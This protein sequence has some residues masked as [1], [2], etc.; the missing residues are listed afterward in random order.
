[1]PPATLL[2]LTDLTVSYRARPVLRQL[3]LRLEGDQ[4]W[5]VLGPNGAGKTTLARVLAGELRHFT[6]A[7]Q[8]SS[9]LA[10]RGVAYVCFERARALL[11]RDRKLDVSEYSADARDTGTHAGDLLPPA[12]ARD[13]WIDRLGLRPLLARGLRYLSTGELRKTLLAS[14]LLQRPGLLLLDSPLDGLDGHSRRVLRAALDTLLASEQRV[15]LLARDPADVPARCSHVLLLDD[16]A[17]VLAGARDEVLAH[18]LQTTLMAPPQPPLG[19]LPATPGDAPRA[20]A[21]A[22][23]IALRDVSVRFEDTPILTGVTWTL[24]HGQ[25]CAISGPNGCGKSTLLGLITGD[26]HKAYGQHVQLFGR[27]RG[28]GESVWDIKRYFGQVDLPLQLGFARGLRLVEVVASGF[29]DSL[30]L[31]D[32]CGD[33]RRRQALAWL[34]ALGLGDRAE[35]PYD[36]LS[37]GL[38]RVVLLARAMVKGPQ[39][40]VLDEPTLGL[41]AFHRRLLLRAVDHVIAASDSQLLFVSHSAA[42]RPGCINQTLDF[43]PG[44]GA[45]SARVRDGAGP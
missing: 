30:G 13:A 4:Q 23:L 27:R 25:H 10:E 22:P 38:Q 36:T 29:F 42:D 34:Q 39:I 16:G 14:A 41:D 19:D 18:P 7:Y 35:A 2:E 9:S 20:A 24:R 32:D 33:A 8:R 21:D 44:D 6:G 12:P 45:F 31:Y 28:S 40:L 17:A 1:M 26:N 11:E 43:V 15:L 37:F 5:A 3:S